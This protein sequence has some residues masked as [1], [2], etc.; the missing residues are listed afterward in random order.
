MVRKVRAAARPH[1][2]RFLGKAPGCVR[3]SAAE[4]CRLCNHSA[5]GHRALRGQAR[6]GLVAR[7]RP[8]AVPNCAQFSPLH[9]PLLELARRS[10][11]R[12][13]R[14]RELGGVPAR[15]R[16]PPP[17][18]SAGLTLCAPFAPC[19][20]AL[21]P[22]QTFKLSQV[23]ATV[24]VDYDVNSRIAEPKWQLE[25]SLGRVLDVQATAAGC[26]LSKNWDADLGA[27]SCNV[28]VR[29]HC[30]WNFRVRAAP[31]G[32]QRGR[33]STLQLTGRAAADAV[34]RLRADPHGDQGCLGRRRVR[35]RQVAGREPARQAAQAAGQGVSPA[36]W[37]R[38]ARVLTRLG[39][40]RSRWAPPST[41]R[42]PS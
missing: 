36:A 35:Y 11:D 18:E 42:A 34:D 12:A 5:H 14:R 10:W 38:A 23:S 7:L 27:M 19:G 9:A 1:G 15:V 37:P 25:S 28:E 2:A 32:H 4:Q 3:W 6:G 31:P 17:P 41:R 24:G 13:G 39:S 29:A 8:G 30:T 21:A 26:T 20:P 33:M 22:F 16:L 40:R